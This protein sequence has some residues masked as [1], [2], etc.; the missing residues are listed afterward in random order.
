[1]WHEGLIMQADNIVKE[2]PQLVIPCSA[3]NNP[4]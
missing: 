3:S 1:M 4:G 2:K